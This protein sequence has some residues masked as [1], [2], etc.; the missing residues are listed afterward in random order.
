MITLGILAVC[1]VPVVIIYT[2]EKRRKKNALTCNSKFL[3]VG[4]ST[5]EYS[6]SYADKLKAICSGMQIKK[7]S[8]VS[9]NTN[10]M[11][12]TLA[13]DLNAGNRYDVIAILGGSNDLGSSSINTKAN[14]QAMYE[15]AKNSGAKVIAITPPNKNFLVN[16]YWIGPGD[17]KIVILNDLV[18]WI[19]QNPLPDVRVNW[20]AITNRKDYFLSDMQHPNSTAHAVLLQEILNKMPIVQ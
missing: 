17:P 4:D 3:F 11:R 19:M 13:A 9:R 5:T 14:L 2:S 6:Q 10:V 7:L 16:Q 15:M 20:N 18:K 8:A 12:D 1:A